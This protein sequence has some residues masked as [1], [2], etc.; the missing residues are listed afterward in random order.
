MRARPERK[1]SLNFALGISQASSPR[2]VEKASCKVRVVSFHVPVP[3]GVFAAPPDCGN[4]VDFSCL[5]LPFELLL[6][7]LP[8]FLGDDRLNRPPTEQIRRLS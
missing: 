1:G 4:G 2:I 6:G 8:S 3:F 7:F 5:N